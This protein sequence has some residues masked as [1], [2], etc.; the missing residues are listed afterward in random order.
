MRALRAAGAPAVLLGLWIAIAGCSS[1]PVI[2]G[3]HTISTKT[4]VA[5]V[6]E[7]LGTVSTDYCDHVALLIIPI[8]SDQRERYD[9]LMAETKRLGGDA[10]VD[11]QVRM[12]DTAWF[13]PLYVK[14]C[15]ELSGTAV[16]LQEAPL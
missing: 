12:Q 11:F 8:V 2:H 15:W 7:V 4:N 14:F 16:K 1:N 5:P 9:E 13:F 6:H 10:I 3:R